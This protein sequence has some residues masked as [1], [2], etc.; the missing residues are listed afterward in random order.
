MMI[1]RKNHD[2]MNFLEKIFQKKVNY[3]LFNLNLILTYNKL[4]LIT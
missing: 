4:K 3:H 2:F 1:L